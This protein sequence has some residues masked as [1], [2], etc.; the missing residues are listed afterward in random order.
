MV[1]FAHSTQQTELNQTLPNGRKQ[2][3]LTSCLKSWGRP[4]RKKWDQNCIHL[5]VFRRPWD[6]AANIFGTTHDRQSGKGRWN[7]QGVVVAPGNFIRGGYSLGVSGPGSSRGLGGRSRS[8]VESVC[9]K[10]LQILTAEAIEIWKLHNYSPPGSWP[11][12]FTVGAKRSIWRSKLPVHAWGRQWQ[13]TTAS[14][15]NFTSVGPQTALNR[16]VI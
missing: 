6:L 5:L 9:R 4:S 8:E 16:T 10:C 1:W 2:I 3:A 11:V 7:L 12:C 15:H 13:G 14:S